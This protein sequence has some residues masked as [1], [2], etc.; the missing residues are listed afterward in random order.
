MPRDTYFVTC[1]RCGE[2]FDE[3]LKACPHCKSPNRKS[4]CRTCGAQIGARV[5]RCPACGAKHRKRMNLFE[6]IVIS[7]CCFFAFLVF[8]AILFPSSPKSSDSG[9][10]STA[11]TASSSVANEP[12][13][14]D[15]S[16]YNYISAERISEFG[17]YMAGE[18]VITKV[19]VSNLGS[20]SIKSHLTDD[21]SYTYD[22]ICEF[23]DKIDGASEGA[24]VIVAGFIQESSSS[25]KTVTIEYCR[26]VPDGSYNMK[27]EPDSQQAYCE[28]LKQAVIDAEA[29]ALAKEKSDYITDCEDVSYSGVSR[30]PDEYKGKKVYI[31]G[32]VIQVQEGFLDT[33]TMRVQTDYGIWYVTYTRKEGES[34]ILENDYIT[35]YGECR[36]VETYVAVLG[37]TI[38]IPSMQMEYYD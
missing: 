32:T 35:C 19:P 14:F 31:S 15:A 26:I 25:A 4:V 18:K 36:G 16:A 6:K 30:N 7:I 11:L 28:T 8:L 37:N 1:P 5:T 9:K 17:K 33:V 3:R 12:A 10:S 34:R 20:R 21:E 23:E 13:V 38:T 27:D 29:A 24:S 2:E 22:I